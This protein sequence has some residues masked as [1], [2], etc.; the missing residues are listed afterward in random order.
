MITR[1]LSWFR[2]LDAS[3]RR[4]APKVRIRLCGF[5]RWIDGQFISNDDWP[6]EAA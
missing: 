5:S 3:K 2:R 6:G 1:V 4:R